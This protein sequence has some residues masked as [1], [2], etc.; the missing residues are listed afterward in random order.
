MWLARCFSVVALVCA[1]DPS[2]YAAANE[3]KAEGK[4]LAIKVRAVDMLGTPIAGHLIEVWQS[5]GEGGPWTTVR[6]RSVDGGKEVRTADDGWASLSFV[7]PSNPPT[8]HGPRTGFCLTAQAKG[9]LVTRGG[10]IDPAASD[11]FEIV[12]TLRRLVSVEG[13]VVDQ[14]GR[15]VADA[16]VFHTG[17]ATPRTEVKT[18]AQGHF[19]LD[20]LPEGKPPIFVT[21]PAYHFHGRLVDASA[22]S[23]EAEPT[24]ELLAT[25]QTPAPLRDACRHCDR[26]RKNSQWLAGSSGRFGKRR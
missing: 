23:R 14:Q 6:R 26:T 20:G 13:H 19:R 11:H 2:C 16:T 25:S 3:E 22:K 17:N 24:I 18:D 15:P 9:F 12:F 1:V 7:L 5:G 21:H 10:R 4:P 8:Y